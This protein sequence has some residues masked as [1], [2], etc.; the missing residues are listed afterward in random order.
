MNEIHIPDSPNRKTLLIVGIAAAVVVLCG[1]AAGVFYFDL[2]N[3]D[4]TTNETSQQSGTI[5][6]ETD[7]SEIGF[8]GASAPPVEPGEH[9]PIDSRLAPD[10]VDLGVHAVDWNS[11]DTQGNV[12]YSMD[13]SDPTAVTVE[14]INNSSSDLDLSGLETNGWAVVS[15]QLEDTI[16]TF[17]VD[18]DSDA[19]SR[20]LSVS[21]GD[22]ATVTLIPEDGTQAV[23]ILVPVLPA[24]DFD[25]DYHFIWFGTTD[26][27]LQSL[28]CC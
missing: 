2:F 15:E 10:L 1:I 23:G 21:A 12:T 22:S 27:F 13:G 26:D 24:E 17:L 8:E 19:S 9:P 16:Y 18:G 25:S 3:S 5:A 20:S 6:A 14:I 11:S 28:F 7:D 4:T